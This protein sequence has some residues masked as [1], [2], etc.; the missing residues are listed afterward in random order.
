MAQTLMEEWCKEARFNI[1]V[2]ELEEWEH[3]AVEEDKDAN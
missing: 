2:W 1:L 3:L